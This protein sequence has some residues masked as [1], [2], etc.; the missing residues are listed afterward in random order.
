MNSSQ[1]KYLKNI[2]E[3]SRTPEN[4]QGQQ[5]VFQESRAQRVLIANSRTILGAQGRLA[6]LLWQQA[7]IDI[8]CH[9]NSIIACSRQILCVLFFAHIPFVVNRTFNA[10]PR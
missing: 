8:T 3:F 2:H 9:D 10:T 7:T 4:T 6:T 5:D 1:I